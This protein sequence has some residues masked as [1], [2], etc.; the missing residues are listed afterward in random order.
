MDDFT[1]NTKTSPIEERLSKLMR[2]VAGLSLGIMLA[3]SLHSSD[4]DQSAVFEDKLLRLAAQ[5]E[6]T[7]GQHKA[8]VLT[9]IKA[10]PVAVPHVGALYGA[11]KSSERATGMHTHDAWADMLEADEIDLRSLPLSD[12]GSPKSG[13][14]FKVE[15]E[16]E[17]IAH[18]KVVQ[19]S[20]T[21]QTAGF[22][23][24]IDD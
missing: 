14:S 18:M 15:R 6:L 13:A 20:A 22:C 19:N 2:L 3:V 17:R 11:S 7:L 16:T 24:Q 8:P 5:S 10:A 1:Y 21:K 23:S 9:P 12:I 4:A